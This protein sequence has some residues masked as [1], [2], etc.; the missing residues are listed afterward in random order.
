MLLNIG[1]YFFLYIFTPLVSGMICGYLL[2]SKSKG[3]L[4]GFLGGLMA[5]IPME[6]ISAPP[7]TEIQMDLLTFYTLM[8]IAAIILASVGLIG[9]YIGGV[10]SRRRMT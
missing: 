4:G 8:I 3:A 9:G 6:L 2:K 7:M 5:F 1:L 10:L